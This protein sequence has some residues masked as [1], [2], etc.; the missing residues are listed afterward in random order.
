MAQARTP[1]RGLVAQ[2]S[3]PRLRQQPMRSM[4]TMMGVALGVAVLIAVVVVNRSIVRGVTATVDHV[5]GRADLQI[6]GGRSGIAE[7]LL[8]VVRAVPGVHK[9]TPVLEQVATIRDPRAARERVLILGVDFLGKEES[10]FRAYKS[11]DLDALRADPLAF[12]NSTSNIVIS[13]KRADRFHYRLHDKIAI[14][15]AQGVQSFEIF[16]LIEAEGA[17]NAFGGAFAVMY[18]PAMQLAFGRGANVDRIDVAATPDVDVNV[19]AKRLERALGS[20]F[21]VERPA[22][23]GARVAHLLKGTRSLLGMASVIAAFIGLFLVYNTIWISVEQRKRE[24]GILRALGATRSDVRTL[25]VVEGTLLGVIG[26]LVGIALG[27]AV[28]SAVMGVVTRMVSELFL[29]IAAA[30]VDFDATVVVTGFVLGVAGSALASYIP[31]RNASRRNVI[32]IIRARETMALGPATARL[33]AQDIVGLSLL[34]ACFVLVQ[35]PPLGS[36]PIGG[37]AA[38]ASLLL[39]SAVLMSRMVQVSQALVARLDT[40]LFGAKAQLANRNLTRDLGRTSTTVGALMVASAMCVSF[41]VVVSSFYTSLVDWVEESARGELYVTGSDKF[42][43]PSFRNT[44]MA[45]QLASEFEALPGVAWVRRSRFTEITYQGAPIKLFSSDWVKLVRRARLTMLEGDTAQVVRDVLA[46]DI[47][48]SENLARHYG[49]HRGDQIVL[50]TQRGPHSFRVAGVMLEYTS[51]IGA[52][53]L[54]RSAFVEHWGDDRVDT[55]E[56]NLAP[57]TDVES[58]RRQINQRY[59]EQHDLFVL[60]NAE[61]RGEVVRL[62]DQLFGLMRALEIVAV[63][64]AA[65]GIVNTFLASVLDRFREIGVLRALGMLRAQVATVILIEAGLVGAIGVM[66][67]II[68]GSALASLQLNH[69][70]VVQLG[71]HFPFR[72]P[73]ASIAQVAVVTTLTAMLAGWYPARQ[74]GRLSVVEALEYE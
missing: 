29:Q 69:I 52:I 64:V 2:V 6:S 66:A 5:A 74:A 8:D 11:A 4:L 65:L 54:D 73:V 60:T 13:R 72:F 59:A 63:L 7:T 14:A 24:F 71:W 32:E 43:G 27:I 25:L 9:L 26:S 42:G 41:K 38:C 33:G 10:F 44:P 20:G 22:S 58:V 21:Q 46:G 57:G 30:Q 19:L 3:I 48:V 16:G 39:G 37:F 28:S 70:N 40:R 34:A 68:V 55:F 17:A 50:A 51:D 1:L 45:P 62:V 35:L 56:I 36:L 15:T 47:T 53:H 18:Y 31:A 49:V 61:Y 67:G 12:L 23:K